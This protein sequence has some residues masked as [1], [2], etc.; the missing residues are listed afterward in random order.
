MGSKNFDEAGTETSSHFIIYKVEHI[1]SHALYLCRHDGGRSRELALVCQVDFRAF[2]SSLLSPNL[3]SCLLIDPKHWVKPLTTALP[4]SC[5]SYHGLGAYFIQSV[6]EQNRFL[7][8]PCLL[9]PTF[10]CPCGTVG[11]FYRQ[12]Y[13]DYSEYGFLVFFACD[14][15][16][17]LCE[18][19]S[20]GHG[21]IGGTLGCV[22]SS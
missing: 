19:I 9:H 13:R 2:E 5:A 3:V 12:T 8:E 1:R 10:S 18:Q 14:T 16:R 22:A 17:V 4:T 6:E 21:L 20:S 15:F 11:L 7:A